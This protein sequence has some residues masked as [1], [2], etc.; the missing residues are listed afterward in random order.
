MFGSDVHS[1]DS[2]WQQLAALRSTRFGIGRVAGYRDVVAELRRNAGLGR[3]GERPTLPF[4]TMKREEP[5]RMTEMTFFD[6]PAVDK[7]LGIVLNL[8]SE[9][10]MLRSQFQAIEQLLD[11]RGV[12]TKADVA[13]LGENEEFRRG[14]QAESRAFA[15]HLLGP[16]TTGD[17]SHVD[18][19]FVPPFG[20]A[21]GA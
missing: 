5:G 20:E 8:G 11:D 13:A 16:L 9:V 6:D 12:V 2:G 15:A 21:K 14:L 10:F 7:L 4:E 19:K 17:A 18:P 3:A 1:T